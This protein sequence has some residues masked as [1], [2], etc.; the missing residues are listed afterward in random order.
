MFNALEIERWLVAHIANELRISEPSVCRDQPFTQMG[1]TSVHAV[2]MSGEL[3]DLLGRQ[4]SPTI[5]YDYPTVIELAAY[6]A[7][8]GAT[9][10]SQEAECTET[11]LRDVDI[12]IIGLGC[13]FP[14]GVRDSE[15]FWRLLDEG[16][17]AI[18]PIPSSRWDIE[19]LYDANPDAIGKMTT[20]FGGFLSDID[21][22][23]PGFFGVSPR[24]AEKMDP[25]QRL[26]LE[27][28]WEA[29]EHARLAPT[30]LMGSNTGVFVGLAYQEYGQ[31]VTNDLAQLDGHAVTGSSGSIASGRL[32]YLLG[33]EGPS[34]TIDTACSSSLVAVHLACQSL[35]RGECGLALAGGVTVMLTPTIFVEFSRLRGLAPDGRCKS[36]SA[37]ADGVAWGEGCGMIVLKRLGDAQR[38][39]DPIL[40]VIRGTAVNQDGRSN[41]LT[42]PN[43]LS[44]QMVVRQALVEAGIPS[45]AVSYVEC[46]GTGTALGDP[47][48]VQALGAVMGHGRSFDEPVLIG[49]V[50]SNI[51]HAQAAA[52]VAGLIKVLLAF[53]HE[54]I[55]KT[56]HFDTPSPHIAWDQLPVQVAKEAVTWKR[57]GKRRRAGVSSFGLS[58]TNV[59]VVLEEAPE[60]LNEKERVNDHDWGLFAITGNTESGANAQ[61]ERL[62]EHLARNTEQALGD[63]A[64]SLATTRAALDARIAVVAGT[65]TELLSVLAAV[66][67]G[68]TPPG[69]VRGKAR[70]GGALAFIFTGQGAQTIGMGKELYTA[71]PVFRIAFDRCTKLF[72]AE[73]EQ[74]LKSVM[75]AGAQDIESALLDQTAYTQAA[76][77]ALE[78]ALSELWR[79][80]GVKPDLVGGHSIGEI[81]AACV[82]GVFVLEDAVSLV[83][84]RGK[85]MQALPKGGTM[86]S[87][88]ASE[89]EVSAAISGYE[90]DVSIA[91]V[92]GPT[93]VVI[94]GRETAIEDV[95]EQFASRGIITKRLIV[96]HAFHSPLMDPMLEEFRRT[97]ER[98]WYSRPTIPIVSNVSGKLAGAEI[99]TPEYWVE[100]VRRAVRFA[101]GVRTLYEAGARTFI[102]VGPRGSL[103]STVAACVPEASL[104]LLATLR[105]GCNET[106]A[107]ME[108]LAGWWVMGGK[109]DWTGVFSSGSRRVPL[110]TYC[111]QHERYW[112]DLPGRS[113]EG[114]NTPI[115]SA[116]YDALAVEDSSDRSERYLTFGPFREI[117]SGFSWLHFFENPKANEEYAR[118]A[119]SAQRELRAVLFRHVDFLNCKAVLDFGCG[120]ATDVITLAQKF[121]H[122]ALDGYTI[123]AEQANIGGERARRAHVSD[124]IGIY[125]RDSAKN[126]FPRKYDLIFGFE[127][128]HHVRDKQALFSN[129]GEHLA[130]DGLLVLADFKSNS[131]TD[132]DHEQSSSFFVVRE[133]WVELL[134]KNNLKILDCVDVSQEIANFLYDPNFDS[135]LERLSKR[136]S[137]ENVRTA[138]T[139]YDQL[140]KIL[141][142]GLANY[143]LLTAKKIRDVDLEEL[144]RINRQ[145][146]DEMVS[147]TNFDEQGTRRPD[148]D[149]WF[150]QLT[151]EVAPTPKA[152]QTKGRWLLLG[153]GE[154]GGQLGR[155]LEGGGQRAVHVPEIPHLVTDMKRLLGETLEGQAPTA[156]VHLGSIESGSS[157]DAESIESALVCGSDSVLCTLQAVAAMGYRDTPRLWIFTRGAQSVGT[158]LL[159]VAQAPLL[160]LGRT[161]AHEHP[162]LRCIRVDLD[163]MRPEG[164]VATLISELL[165]NDGE[166]EVVWRAGERRVA[167]LVRRVPNGNRRERLELIG[168]RAY[169][170]ELDE[171]GVLDRMVLRAVK[172]DKPGVGEVEIAVDAAGLNFLDVL[173]ALGLMPNDSSGTIERP[174]LFGGECSGQ[175]VAVG[176][177]VSGLTV[178]QSVVALARGAFASR[179]ITNA[180]L[181]FP[182]PPKLS[183]QEAAVVPVAY[184]TAWYALS[185]VARL[186]RGE[187][188]LIHAATGGVGLAAVAWAKHV[189]AEI[190]AT[191]SS[192]EKRDYLA[193]L[194]VRYVSDSRSDQFVGDVLKWTNG[195]GVDVVLNFLSGE[196]IAKSFGLLRAFGRFVEIG[197]LDYYSD[198]QLGLRPFLRNLSFSL[199]DVWG[200]LRERPEW[201]RE[202]LVEMLQ[203]FDAEVFK[204]PP[205]ETFPLSRAQDAFAKMAQAKHVGKI[206]LLPSTQ[207]ETRVFVPAT[208]IVIRATNSYLVTGGLGGL[209]LSVAEWLVER[210]AGHLVLA[211]RSGAVTEEQQKAVAALRT[212]GTRVTVVEVDVADRSALERVLAEIRA[213]NMPLS[214]VIH[215]AGLVDDGVLLEQ[216]PERLR[217]V[218][219]PKIWGAIHLD[220]LTRE[221]DLDFFVLYASGAGLLGSPG[222]GNYAAANSFLDA[223]AERRRAE[224]LPALSVD[225]GAF[226]EVGLA[227]RNDNRGTRLATLGM[228]SLTPKEGISVL[229]RLLNMDNA[230]IGVIP[231]NGRQWVESHPTVAS[232]RML[233]RL[234]AGSRLESKGN[235][236]LLERLAAS[237]PELRVNLITETIRELASRVLRIP[238]AKLDVLAPLTG[239]GMD[240]LM[241]LELRNRIEDLLGVKV[242]ATLL[243][244]YPTVSALSVQLAGQG[245]P[246]ARDERRTDTV[247]STIEESNEV[248]PLDEDGLLAL[249][250]ESLARAGKDIVS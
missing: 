86:V 135:N 45:S 236:R 28:S 156:V 193:S 200:M 188:V 147:F 107:V 46:H 228:R 60:P 190:Y 8:V 63:V 148:E 223:L 128:A 16:R 203:M 214:G 53:E 173:M 226:S 201:G 76:L 67:K 54:R 221:D 90:N 177:G 38:D 168:E 169:R 73:L 197:K 181:V 160:G 83:A 245:H 155:A 27:T 111:W 44:Q 3:S 85:L 176:D 104:Q 145:A 204:L 196:L 220:E 22:F 143:I 120:Y 164:E 69:V 10:R 211:G 151:W 187:R 25:Q 13:R 166:D 248:V 51:A 102:E 171:P 146:L 189:G 33:L 78:F 250:D 113:I 89:A 112:Y 138:F 185:K 130:E 126:P 19:A 17:D 87:I 215:A 132:I 66:A 154:L 133:K 134:S 129:I 56:L 167:R 213:T 224:R 163:P 141:R 31:L 144:K 43:G 36:F 207:A 184:L 88:W 121:P 234:I 37:E 198:R 114:V 72:D 247:K 142:S 157:Y 30:S 5:A 65:R 41:G 115:A 110:P 216:T 75:W 229:E 238:E 219:A 233:S 84:A 96:S 136:N 192:T 98:L 202:L 158:E 127:V 131:A 237:E 97:A 230:Q 2:G 11:A 99:G 183:A 242:P 180:N 149:N 79:S 159:A 119:L 64:Y 106:A 12:A 240:S 29:I 70:A 40:G 82:A 235:Q 218:M 178:G 108:G 182:K 174:M 195:E 109:V 34:L 137:D 103:L 71:W 92:N 61:S 161:I 58:G 116:Y 21:Q 91:A 24:E 139:S 101:D 6:V 241:G 206:V 93:Q 212:K 50:K 150:L 153:G 117:I 225:W 199:V 118:L 249:L 222:Q 105:R 179:V 232:S 48:E 194:G 23:D 49:S 77:F 57:N 170:L 205:I 59:H 20:R 246:D 140:G 95:V 62:V 227:A 172:V 18:T 208:K 42:A 32:S 122:L 55:P 210:G 7:Q 14:G 175:I 52:G 4:L 9:S 123:S 244:T 217:K 162:D 186:T 100:H 209:G 94:S 125:H 239:L 243:W 124:R 35:R 191:A 81:V 47:I 39:G 26:V 15:S 152:Q 74:P 1:L 80:W 68:E 231:I 165:A